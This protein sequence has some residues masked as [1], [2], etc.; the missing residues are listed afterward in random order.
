MSTRIALCASLVGLVLISSA[1]ANMLTNGQLDK[2]SATPLDQY[3]LI[4]L[5]P[6]LNSTALPGWTITSGTVDIVPNA[7]WPTS[8]VA[9]A[10]SLDLV[11]SP[12]IGAI[13][14]SVTT[15]ATTAYTLTFDLAANP[16]A[17][18]RLE[19]GTT[20]ILRVEALAADGTTVL[21]STDYQITKGTRTLQDMQWQANS[22]NFTATGATSILRLAALTPLNLPNGATSSNIFTGP[23]IDN[24]NLIVGGNP[25]PAPEPA[26]LG[27]LGVSASA[28]LLRRRRGRC[29]PP[30]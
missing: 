15:V 6:T 28:L 18:P 3:G 16:E 25:T 2:A 14:Q 5:S 30:R 27:L 11:G 1:R 20:K 22:F 8:N 4:T 26:S 29:G 23:V 13:S 10:Y 21:A 9:A 24:L 7:Y 17:G 19:T 12:G